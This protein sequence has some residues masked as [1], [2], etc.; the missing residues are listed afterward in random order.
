MEL[1]LQFY[2]TMVS[3]HNLQCQSE[4]VNE[5][6]HYA[7][8]IVKRRVG[9]TENQDSWPQVNW[10]Y[11]VY[12]LLQQSV[13]KYRLYNNWSKTLF[14]RFTTGRTRGALYTAHFMVMQKLGRSYKLSTLVKILILM[15][16]NL[17][18]AS[19]TINL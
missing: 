16:F 7:I 6:N 10:K 14:F 8:A 2:A 19:F 15:K 13:W 11:F 9:Y 3:F 17:T 18:R 12:V 5:Q 4:E 1:A